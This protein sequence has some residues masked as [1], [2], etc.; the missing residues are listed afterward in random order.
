M[1]NMHKTYNINVL[2]EGNWK[3]EAGH[4]NKFYWNLK[5]SK[6]CYPYKIPEIYLELYQTSMIELFYKP[7]PLS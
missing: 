7:F 5:K 2:P 3:R 4:N 1:K 6:N